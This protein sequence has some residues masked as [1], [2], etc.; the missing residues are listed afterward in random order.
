MD[1]GKTTTLYLMRHGQTEDNVRRVIQ[2]H[3]DSPLTRE[4]ITAT[5]G[6]AKMLKGII[7]DAIFCSDLERTR[8][9]LEIL[10]DESDINIIVNY[11]ADLRE[12]DFGQLTGKNIEDIKDIILLHKKQTQRHYTDGESGDSFSK[13]VLGFVEMVL[14]VH[15][16]GAILFMTHFGVIETILKH[17]INKPDDRLNT[18]NYDM[19]VLYFDKKGVNYKWI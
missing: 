1:N 11:C 13:R 3:N 19:G 18:K 6:R 4:G 2:S 17:Y 15:E 8:K 14:D 9:S 16:G 5:R 7:F 12:I 10:L